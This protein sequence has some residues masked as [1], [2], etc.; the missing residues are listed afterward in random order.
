MNSLEHDPKLRALLDRLH[1]QSEAQMPQ[2][3]AHIASSGVRVVAGSDA[4]VA[5]DK[6]F[7]TDKLVALDRDK[8]EFCYRLCRA[9]GARRVV[10]AGTSYGVSTLYLASAV[11]DNGGGTVIATEYE[12]AKVAQA[13]AH[14]A[15]AGLA[16]QIEL[17]EGDLRQTLQRLEGPIDFLLVDI[18]I[19]MIVPALERVAPHMR[20]GAV[21]VADN[22]AAHRDAYAPYFAYLADHGFTTQTLPFEGGLE[23]SVKVD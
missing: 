18:W 8:A 11:R 4:E 20:R 19:P 16:A 22:T 7:W 1:V 12:P 2:L 23:L 14:F 17:R 10:E 5:A 13:R 9:I 15:E 6:P 3:A 21:I